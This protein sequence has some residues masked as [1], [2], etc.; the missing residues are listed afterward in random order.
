MYGRRT[1]PPG[2][3]K[4]PRGRGGEE[5]SS[6]PHEHRTDMCS[7]V[8]GRMT[9]GAM[10]CESMPGTPCIMVS[11]GGNSAAVCGIID[12][13]QDPILS[14]S[15]GRPA[16]KTHLQQAKVRVA[17]R[18]TAMQP[19][20]LCRHLGENGVP[21]QA[22]TVPPTPQRTQLSL[23]PQT[24]RTARAPREQPCHRRRTKPRCGPGQPRWWASWIQSCP[25]HR[26]R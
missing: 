16:V 6:S 3:P 17:Q 24:G 25:P 20:A 1:Y 11:S 5:L 9:R 22:V 2:R 7:R 13:A 19:L 18:R 14:K 12:R 4:A 8:N 21:P 23:S 15:P 26:G 10:G